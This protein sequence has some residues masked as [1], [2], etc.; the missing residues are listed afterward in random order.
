MIFRLENVRGAL[1]AASLA[2]LCTACSSSVNSTML[3]RVTDGMKAGQVE[4]LL[5]QPTRI[6]Q[7]EVPD[8]SGI[9]SG[10]VYHYTSTQ[11]D[12]QV[13]FVNDAVFKTEFVPE[14]KHA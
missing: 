7:A 13:V 14:G 9:I 2:L 10:K 5:G 3:A 12:A 4:T 6:E 11:G 8:M 1:A